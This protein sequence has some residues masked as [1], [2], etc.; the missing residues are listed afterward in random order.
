MHVSENAIGK[1]SKMFA[2][3]HL[4]HEMLK[5]HFH[6]CCLYL[7]QTREQYTPFRNV[8]PCKINKTSKFNVNALSFVFKFI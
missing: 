6:F 5:C 4:V 7:I 8:L 1:N 3:S 2:S